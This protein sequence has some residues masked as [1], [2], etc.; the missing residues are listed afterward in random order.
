MLEVVTKWDCAWW[1]VVVVVVAQLQVVEGK[2]LGCL[3][4]E[5]CS[6]WGAVAQGSSVHSESIQNP[7]KVG[8]RGSE[9]RG[10]TA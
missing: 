3:E 4:R 9:V 1:L 7:G 8:I 2:K 6:Q 10:K 5:E